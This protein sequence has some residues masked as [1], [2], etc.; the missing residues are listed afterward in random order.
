M[1]LRVRPVVLLCAVAGTVA[2]AAC[3]AKTNSSSST[4]GSSTAAKGGKQGGSLTVVLNS[5]YDGAWPAGLDPVTNTNGAANQSL[6]NSIYGQLIELHEGGKL[7]PG[8][9]SAFKFS[10]GG[11]TF[12]ITIRPGVKFTDGTPFNAEVVADHINKVLKSPCTCR[13]TWP[14]K[15]VTASGSR[16]GD[17]LH[18]RVRAGR[19][20]VHRLQ[21]Q[22]DR[23]AHREAEDGRARVPGHP[24]GRRALH[25][26]EQQ[27]Q[28]ADR[29]QE[30]PDVLQEGPP[31]PGP[32][33]LQVDR[34]RRGGL[35]GAAGRAGAGLREHVDAVAHR[36][37]EEGPEAAGHPAALDLAVRHPAQHG[38]P[39]V[40]QPQGAPGDL[41]RHRLRGDP[42]Q[43][44]PEPLPEHAGL[45]RPRRPLLRGRRA[46]LPHHRPR[47]GQGAGQGA[48]RPEDRAGHDQRAR[49]QADHRG[50]AEPVGAG[51]DQDDHQVL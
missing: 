25:G 14:V 27:A 44:V 6:M 31:L 36:P 10:N 28:L 51:R 16:R 18:H 9:A 39:A 20:V 29:A 5:G 33:D 3:G 40:Q 41:L 19:G 38:R 12:T 24:G 35:P 1:R 26:G 4:S 50:A 43:A 8:L 23:L 15:S 37:D 46:R 11:K 7:V 34:R 13:P 49:G 45:H 32:A 22:L 17:R 2:L 30:E 47:E 42:L 48:R 21:R